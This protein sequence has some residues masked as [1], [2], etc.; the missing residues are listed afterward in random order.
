MVD[1]MLVAKTRFS[2]WLAKHGVTTPALAKRTGF[3]AAAVSAWRCGVRRP[4]IGAKALIAKAL[5]L[6]VADLERLL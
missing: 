5:K 2:K 6:K 1:A 4:G 3:S